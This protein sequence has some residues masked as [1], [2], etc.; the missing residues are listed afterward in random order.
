MSFPA[1]WFPAI[2]PGKY[3]TCVNPAVNVCLRARVTCKSITWGCP[4][5]Y[6]AHVTV[7][8]AIGRLNDCFDFFSRAINH[9]VMVDFPVRVQQSC[10]RLPTM[11]KRPLILRAV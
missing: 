9:L 7:K 4:L 3:L 2:G 6:S 1:V 10:A 8:V 5:C 11:N